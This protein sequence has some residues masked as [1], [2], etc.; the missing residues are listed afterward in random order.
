MRI[1]LNL[2]MKL[3]K[4]DK[5]EDIL[6]ELLH[7]LIE[8]A[9]TVPFLFVAYLLMEFIEHKASEKMENSLKKIGNAGPAIGSA[10]G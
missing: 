10:L 5:M 9:K 2:R 4:E 7:A 1:V 8:T 3:K 6:H